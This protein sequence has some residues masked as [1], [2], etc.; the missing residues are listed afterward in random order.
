MRVHKGLRELKQD[1]ANPPDF[2][3]DPVG[4]IQ[5]L[6]GHLYDTAAGAVGDLTTAMTPRVQKQTGIGPAPVPLSHMLK[7]VLASQPT[8]RTG[9]PALLAGLDE[10]NASARDPKRFARHMGGAAE[11]IVNMIPFNEEGAAQ[12]AGA[13]LLKPTEK[14]AGDLIHNYAS[15]LEHVSVDWLD[16]LYSEDRMNLSQ[17]QLD[18]VGQAFEDRGTPSHVTIGVGRDGKTAYIA[19]G[20]N[21]IEA[22]R[23]KGFTHVPVMVEVG[24]DLGAGHPVLMDTV[25]DV[26]PGPGDTGVQ[27]YYRPS[28]VF[29]SLGTGRDAAAEAASAQRMRLTKPDPGQRLYHGTW[30]D[31]DEPANMITKG[32]RGSTKL[33]L[34][35]ANDPRISES[36]ASSEGGHIRPLNAPSEQHFFEVPQWHTKDWYGYNPAH[37]KLTHSAE[38]DDPAVERMLSH[39]VFSN[40]PEMLKEY[41]Q[42]HFGNLGDNEAT[43]LAHDLARGF[44][45]PLP[46]QKYGMNLEE[47]LKNR[48][49]TTFTQSE[50]EMV[51]AAQEILQ[52]KGYKGVKYQNTAPH[53]TQHAANKDSYI[54]FDPQHAMTPFNKF[55]ADPDFVGPSKPWRYEEHPLIAN[56]KKAFQHLAIKTEGEADTASQAL[57]GRTWDERRVNEQIPGYSDYQYLTQDVG[58]LT[59]MMSQ[60]FD[61]GKGNMRDVEQHVNNALKK[62]TDTDFLEKARALDIG[63]DPAWATFSHHHS[64]LPVYNEMQRAARDA[65]VAMGRRQFSRAWSELLRIKQAINSGQYEKAVGEFDPHYW[66]K[67]DR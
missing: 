45:V 30:K 7:Q 58:A 20:K 38:S 18:V 25:R 48:G 32:Y 44:T 11:Q 64:R 13:K 41:L 27:G 52:S 62:L 23:R 37:D 5:R 9:K 36:F 6:T 61:W 3:K 53:E 28:Q 39:V 14:A 15:T 26:I 24:K 60:S 35:A 34:H 40:R 51:K 67:T 54:I 49:N 65:A 43:A 42:H 21:I 29:R 33:G 50:D 1:V 22:A 59:R 4:D 46:H 31:Y 19:G 12:A 16:R 56:R 17:D 55:I 57:G 10:W 8:M 47:L 63:K 66:K 2:Q